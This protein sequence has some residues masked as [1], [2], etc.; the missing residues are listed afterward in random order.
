MAYNNYSYN[1]G[2]G[3]R[4][5]GYGYYGSRRFN[6][7]NNY[8]N[9]TGNRAPMNYP[10]KHSGCKITT[11]RETGEQVV[12]GW[13]Y[14]KQRGMISF[15]AAPYKGTKVSKSRTGREWENWFVKITNKRTMQTTNH[16]CLWDCQRRRLLIKD[17]NMVANPGAPN[18]GYF[19]QHVSKK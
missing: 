8:R 9:N 10:R 1:G 2:G 19:G 17:L 18:G 12:V 14:S 3:Y 15:I 16:S 6:G 4:N 13:N 11:V 7:Y 5:P